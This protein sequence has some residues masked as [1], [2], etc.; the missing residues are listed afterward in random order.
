MHSRLWSP[1]LGSLRCFAA[2][3]LALI[4]CAGC[5][6]LKSHQATEQL[7]ISSAVDEAVKQLDF[8]PL[9]GK[10]VFVD[11][12]YVRDG[13]LYGSVHDGYLVSAVRQQM[14]ADGCLLFDK[15]EDAEVVV[16]AR[17][18]A[19]ASD[20]HEITYGLPASNALSSAAAAMGSTA[21]LPAIPEIA[22]AKRTQND[23]AAKLALFA[24]DAQ[25]REPLWQSG[26]MLSKTSTAHTW[27]LGAGPWPRSSS[28]TGKTSAAWS[29]FRKRSKNPK[30]ERPK[31]ALEEPHVFPALKR[32]ILEKEMEAIAKKEAGASGRVADDQGVA[33][34]S[35]ETPVN[36]SAEGAG[37][38][39]QGDSKEV[40]SQP[41]KSPQEGAKETP[42]PSGALGQ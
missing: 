1:P 26:V 15:R 4:A 19:L 35:A 39:A 13:K 5:G 14:M 34:A 29:L 2:A 20:S 24:F 18:G 21:P 31:V 25:T 9:S 3:L 40:A 33:R 7:L 23:G 30:D 10:K 12:T 22:L 17:V 11:T 6:Q 16:E 42:P 36:P 32:S 41:A 8:S 28:S 27:L 37:G 38:A